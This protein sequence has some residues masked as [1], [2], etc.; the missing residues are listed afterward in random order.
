MKR[1]VKGD[2]P[3]ELAELLETPGATYD[4]E[5]RETKDAIR[6]DGLRD[7]FWICCYC[8]GALPDEVSLQQIEHIVAQSKAPDRTLDWSNMLIS[9][10]SGRPQVEPKGRSHLTCDDHK[11]HQDLAI[12]PLEAECEGHFLYARETGQI[13]PKTTLAKQTIQVLNLDCPRLRRNRLEALNVAEELLQTL[14]EEE[15]RTKFTKPINGRLQPYEPAI[16]TLL[17]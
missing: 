12:S 4:S 8:C 2:P 11:A 10:S 14:P 3:Q 1:I 15:W 13:V 16:R 17:S 6:R 9:C 7:Q 5:S